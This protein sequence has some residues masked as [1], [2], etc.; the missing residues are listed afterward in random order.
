MTRRQFED[1][2]ENLKR[3]W[4]TK[5]PNKITSICANE[6][7]WY[8][9]PFDNPLTT[10]EQ[11][12]NEWQSVLNQKHI[13]VSYKIL[14]ITDNIGIAQWHANFTRLPSNEPAELDGIFQITLDAFGCCTEFRQWY[15]SKE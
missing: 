13:T 2:L 5:T 6:F 3:I 4:E 9:T 7:I 14:C 12:L 8:E 1:W 10:K 15:N 11:L